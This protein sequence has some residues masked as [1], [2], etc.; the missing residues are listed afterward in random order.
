M[1]A[2]VDFVDDVSGRSRSRSDR[3]VYP[4][5]ADIAAGKMPVLTHIGAGFIGL[6]EGQRI[7]W[8]DRSG[9][10]RRL[11]VCAVRRG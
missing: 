9:M 2:A 5:E 8:P 3:L 6:R 10:A 1:N 7:A 11:R 4:G